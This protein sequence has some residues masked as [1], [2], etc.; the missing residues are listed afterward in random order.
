MEK[1]IQSLRS[2]DG[3]G[4]KAY[5]SIQGHYKFT[6]FDL[7]IDY[8]QGD[9]FATPSKIRVIVP[10]EERK[11]HENW[12]ATYHR[13]T[14]AED[15]IAR[16]VGQAVGQNSTFIKGSGKSGLI[17]F[18]APHQE[19]LERSAVSITAKT[20]TICF[21][22]GLPANGRRINGRE[23]EK[24][25]KYA[26][27]A[28]INNSIFTIKDLDIEQAMMLADQQQAIREKMQANNWIA[29][30]ANGA[31]LPRSSGVNDRP[32]KQ[33]VPFVSPSENE[34][35]IEIPHQNKPLKGMAIKKGITLIVG[36]GYHGKSTLLEAIER[37][38]YNHTKGDGREY[39]L[40]DLRAVKIR[41]EDGRQ[42]TG[43]T[44]SPF[45]TNLPHKQDT[46]FFTTEN[47]SGSTS[48]A[49]NVMEALE[50]GASTLLID[51]D[52]SA[53]NFMIRDHRMQQLVTSEQEPIT[54]FI[55][56][57]KQLHDQFAVSTIIVMGGSGDYFD[58]ADDVIMM[59]EYIP[60][61]VTVKAREI[62]R[63]YP[64]ERTITSQQDFGKIL[65]RNL[66]QSSLQTMKGKRAKV[67]AKG[68][69][70]ILMGNTE[71]TFAQ[72]EQLVDPSQTRMIAE[73]IQYLDKTN[74]LTKSLTLAQLL[75]NINEQMDQKGLAT[76]T[77]HPDQHPGD[78][79]RPR[80]FEIAAVLNRIRTLRVN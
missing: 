45:I 51:E 68:L 12:L 36:G 7:F 48:Q 73:I 17:Q 32:L 37:G 70:S 43:V 67:Q 72:T 47:A 25:F 39:V 63:Q 38:V 16:S 65:H 56:R 41:A 26:I 53:T 54:P 34:I 23:A 62:T 6:N 30:I 14:S 40:T 11:V 21:S 46:D 75:D 4:Y 50:V 19:I 80:R 52:T 22:I 15:C 5:K 24:L 78:L 58:V 31:I 66:E 64:A 57:V 49:A 74:G 59:E 60:K 27:P 18:D 2:I 13:K 55:D 28:I 9:P 3:K 10:E 33:G 61:N 44:I 79:A 1:L 76:Y 42:V 35:E 20:I 69:T 8:V 71:I 77:A 29:F